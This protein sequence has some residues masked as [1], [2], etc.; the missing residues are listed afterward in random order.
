[1]SIDFDWQIDDA[2]APWSEDQPPPTRPRRK[3]SRRS[4]LIL[5]LIPMLAIASAAIYVQVTL[6]AQLNRATG[7][8]RQVARLEAQAV[9]A[10]DRALFEA[11]QNPEDGPW[12]ALQ[13]SRFGRLERV[14]LPEFGWAATGAQPQPGTVALEPG[15]ARLDVTYRFSVTQPLPGGATHV[16]LRAP[17][18][19]K[20]TSSGWVRAMPGPDFWGPLRKLNGN[21][22]SMAYTQ[23]DAAFVE[24]LVPRLD[25]LLVRACARLD[26]PPQ[27]I[28]ISFENSAEALASLSDFSYGLENGFILR[29]PS[30]HLIGLPADVPSHDELYRAVGT[31]VVQAL[32]TSQVAYGRQLDM[33]YLSSQELVRWELAQAGLAGPF[34]N[35]A[36]TRTLASRLPVAAWPP[37]S[38]L[39]LRP[40][41][42]G[43]QSAPGEA[44]VPLA[45]DFLG[46]Q[47][48]PGTVTRLL[49]AL[50][51]ARSRTLGDAIRSTLRVNPLSLEPAWQ[52]Y[53]LDQAGLSPKVKA[54]LPQGELALEC[55]TDPSAVSF[56]ILRIH[57][58]GTDLTPMTDQGQSAFDPAWSPD[59]RRLAFG[60]GDQVVV[61]DANDRRVRTN[62]P[63][64]SRSLVRFG[65]LPDGQ[66]WIDRGQAGGLFRV[67][68][69]TGQDVAIQGVRPVLSPDGTRMAYL[70]HWPDP[71]IWIADSNGHNAHPVVLGYG[72]N[73]SPDGRQLAQETNGASDPAWSPDGSMI[74]VTVWQS[75]GPAFL[76]LDS[77]TGAVLARKRG[78]TLSSRA[79]SADG[80]YVA[81]QPEPDSSFRAAV[82]I[83]DVWNDRQASLL[84]NGWD[85]S[86]DG[87]WLA[88]TQ[89][90]AG[91]LLTTPDLT[92]SRW[93]D[94]PECSNV[95]W[96]PSS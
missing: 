58:D 23:R 71:I 41:R 7:P 44:L 88:V 82:G 13:D 94:T 95:T 86:P 52:A 31:R 6:G 38:A 25:E 43:I 10:N 17:Q 12:R 73:G 32:V 93:L 68:L 80:R 2:D 16:T 49:P 15:G 24:P 33:S 72:L 74:A 78:M 22:V 65:W 57:A 62:I 69:D 75:N 39:L 4:W 3:L 19:Y 40:N 8:V 56:S 61:M 90:P 35:E 81:F 48:G 18:Y 27:P 29:L 36:I 67:N 53:L 28:Y 84:G 76:V 83:L 79:W 89:K 96:R 92:V 64:G 70:E 55:M 5:S 37:L 54:T 59:G 14:G 87:Q 60:Q 66:L 50:I 45:F 63:G 9:A 21:R 1:M 91:V 20:Q 11:L 46:Q 47:F 51:S 85:W 34:I 26:C 42:V 30:P 77:G